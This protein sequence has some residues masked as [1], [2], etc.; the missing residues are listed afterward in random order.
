MKNKKYK[1][2]GELIHNELIEYLTNIDNKITEI[3]KPEANIIKEKIVNDVNDTNDTIIRFFKIFDDNLINNQENLN[4]FNNYFKNYKKNKN[5]D[6]MMVFYNF[7]TIIINETKSID[8]INNFV[9][10]QDNLQLNKDVLKLISLYIILKE[11]IEKFNEHVIKNFSK[12]KVIPIKTNVAEPAKKTVAAESAKETVAETTVPVGSNEIS[13]NNVNLEFSNAANEVQQGTAAEVP[14]TSPAGT[15]AQLETSAEPASEAAATGTQAAEPAAAEPADA[16]ETAE[17]N[18]SPEDVHVQISKSESA[19]PGEINRAEAAGTPAAEIQA[20]AGTQ[21]V[22]TLAAE[23]EAEAA[24]AEAAKEEQLEKIKQAKNIIKKTVETI[25]QLINDKKTKYDNVIQFVKIINDNEEKINLIFKEIE[26]GDILK[27]INPEEKLNEIKVKIIETKN[28]VNENE[29]E[30]NNKI[31]EL[32]KYKN[33]LEEIVLSISKEESKEEEYINNLKAKKNRDIIKDIIKLKL[34][35]LTNVKEFAEERSKESKVYLKSAEKASQNIDNIYRQIDNKFS[36][37]QKIVEKLDLNI[38]LTDKISPKNATAEEPTIEAEP[39]AEAAEKPKDEDND[40]FYNILMKYKDDEENTYSRDTIR[41]LHKLIKEIDLKEN[42]FIKEENDYIYIRDYIELLNTHYRNTTNYKIKQI[43]LIPLIQD[44]NYIIKKE[45]NYIDRHGLIKIDRANKENKNIAAIN[46]NIAQEEKKTLP[47]QGGKTDKQE[48]SPKNTT[49]VEGETEAPQETAEG[50]AEGEEDTSDSDKE[51]DIDIDKDIDKDNE[52]DTNIEENK[53]Q[54]KN[55]EDEHD[56]DKNDVIK[57]LINYISNNID[58]DPTYK[59]VDL[60]KITNS[61]DVKEYLKIKKNL[62]GTSYWVVDLEKKVKERLKNII[63]ELANKEEYKDKLQNSSYIDS[64]NV[65]TT[66]PLANSSNLDDSEQNVPKPKNKI[67]NAIKDRIEKLDLSSNIE[68]GKNPTK[69]LT[70]TTM[71]VYDIILISIILICISTVI[72]NVINMIKFLYECFIEI[73]N[74]QYNDVK[75]ENTFRYKLLKYITYLTE[76]DI[77]KLIKTFNDETDVNK[78]GNVFDK[79]KNIFFTKENFETQPSNSSKNE[80]EPIFNIFLILK[81]YYI[82]IKLYLSLFIICIIIFTVF[83]LIT[84]ASIIN[85]INIKIDLIGDQK[86]LYILIKIGLLSFIYISINFILY[87]YYFVNKIY[88]KYYDTYEKIKELDAMINNVN[89]NN[90]PNINSLNIDND[91]DSDKEIEKEVINYIENNKTLNINQKT[92]LILLYCCIL[93]DIKNE[94]NKDDIKHYIDSIISKTK[95]VSSYDDKTLYS[96]ISNKNRKIPIKYYILD[97]ELELKDKSKIIR[98]VNNYIKQI[99]KK[100]NDINMLFEDDNYIIDLGWYF[101][102]S[103]IISSLYITSV[104]IIIYSKYDEIK[105]FKNFI[106]INIP[107]DNN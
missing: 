84:V 33:I 12:S 45:K 88:Q 56:L 47:Q 96:L 37:Q 58:K 51:I 93:K 23:A 80:K 104:I 35:F 67:M 13:L 63:N 41:F 83:K 18:V 50:E 10:L 19:V 91:N 54:D 82:G 94:N 20:Q 81:L 98:E 86:L 99:N 101:L 95:N 71:I 70:K 49:A 34:N 55:D 40:K 26:N 2:G 1:K 43:T 16:A 32:Q 107:N 89:N 21:A 52:Q 68:D 73:G 22:D 66:K 90:F 38:I 92:I 14:L 15:Q 5:L 75:T 76:S 61:L 72:L 7:F 106:N 59:E 69:I 79:I 48:L 64:K 31:K 44:H 36:E 53:L 74:I 105:D 60:K 6:N 78:V 25:N 42:E 28:F 102:I 24:E 97:K 62:N 30:I 39:A 27:E 65:D 77:P 57:V 100:I 85:N 9:N 46:Y 17:K 29:K 87:K 4:S 8:F 103:L 11:N 3:K